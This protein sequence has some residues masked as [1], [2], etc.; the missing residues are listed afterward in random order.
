MA[1]PVSGVASKNNLV[2]SDE[3]YQ[4]SKKIGA[5]HTVINTSTT[6]T[7]SST[8]TTPVTPLPL[9]EG[10]ELFVKSGME[11]GLTPWEK[12]DTASVAVS[13]DEHFS[14]T[15]SLYI[16][17]RGATGAGVQQSV[18][19]KIKTGAT[20]KFSAKVKY[21]SGPAT[22]QF[23]FDIQD[24]DWTTIK[25]LGSGVMTKGEWG[26]IEGTY[27]VPTFTLPRIFI[28]TIWTT[29]VEVNCQ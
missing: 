23:N 19:G 22:K 4:S 18:T 10:T 27:T 6:S 25:I 29:L 1:I 12:H 7:T 9:N 21:N 16:S 2:A 5:S 17:G 28:E 26:T 3:L 13:T 20:Y 24:G 8:V 11:N 15:N 14:G